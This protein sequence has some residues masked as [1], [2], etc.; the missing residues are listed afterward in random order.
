MP[1]GCLYMSTGNLGML[2]LAVR[3]KINVKLN[4]L[5]PFKRKTL[6]GFKGTASLG[7]KQEHA[8]AYGGLSL[9]NSPSLEVPTTS[10]YYSICCIPAWHPGVQWIYRTAPLASKFASIATGVLRKCLDL[11]PSVT[12]LKSFSESFTSALMSVLSEAEKPRFVARKFLIFLNFSDFDVSPLALPS[13][14]SLPKDC[15]RKIFQSLKT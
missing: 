5:L 15:S 4:K 3:S 1:S 8:Q 10:N 12:H 7:D 14:S 2:M 6:Q 9:I 13:A 11:K